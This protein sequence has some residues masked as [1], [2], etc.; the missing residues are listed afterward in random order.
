[1]DVDIQFFDFL[2]PDY[3]KKI[4]KNKEKTENLKL[5]RACDNFKLR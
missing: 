3:R 4:K 5:H 1:M 2:C